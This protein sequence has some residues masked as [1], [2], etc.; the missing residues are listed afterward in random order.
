MGG[1]SGM[2]GGMAGSVNARARGGAGGGS[3]TGSGRSL[4]VRGAT[5]AEGAVAAMAIDKYLHNRK[6][7]VVDWA[8]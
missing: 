6:Q 4:S 8:K 5:L 1:G 3:L 2:G 7:M